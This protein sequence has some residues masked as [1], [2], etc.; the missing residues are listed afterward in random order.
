MLDPVLRIEV[1]SSPPNK[2]QVPTG[3]G[4]SLPPFPG[5][6]RCRLP[7]HWTSCSLFPMP[8]TSLNDA[9]KPSGLPPC[10]LSLCAHLSERDLMKLS[11]SSSL[12][13]GTFLSL[14]RNYCESRTFASH[15]PLR[16]HSLRWGR[17]HSLPADVSSSVSVHTGEQICAQSNQR[18]VV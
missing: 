16:P 10:P 14:E 5:H 12:F 3:L 2:C 11:E 13:M 9:S 1:S 7:F 6:R 4:P 8:N 15:L 18:Q 17:V